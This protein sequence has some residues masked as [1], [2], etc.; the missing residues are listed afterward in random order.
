MAKSKGSSTATT[1]CFEATALRGSASFKS[2]VT[3]RSL[4]VAKD[5]LWLT[6]DK[7]RNNM[8]AAEYNRAEQDRL[9][10]GERGGA[11]QYFLTRCA[12]AEGKLY[13]QE[14]WALALQQRQSNCTILHLDMVG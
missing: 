4:R 2:E 6:A 14:K 8:D 11:H 3:L 9:P 5:N 1:R 12:S 10:L 7:L 13:G